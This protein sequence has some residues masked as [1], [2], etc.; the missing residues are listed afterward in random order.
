MRRLEPN[1][2]PKAAPA[3]LSGEG[4]IG[5]VT[6]SAVQKR[7]GSFKHFQSFLWMMMDAANKRLG[8]LGVIRFLALFFLGL[9][10]LQTVIKPREMF[11][12]L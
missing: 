6:N 8:D 3:G 1:L 5:L 9:K 2:N 7:V 12:F 10:G 4:P 11:V